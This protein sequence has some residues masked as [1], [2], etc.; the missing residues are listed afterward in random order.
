MGMRPP[1]FQRKLPSGNKV[2]YYQAYDATGTRTSPM[3]TWQRCKTA[4]F[5]VCMERLRRENERL[6]AMV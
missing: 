1:L 2:Y 5:V 3:S 6:K 4:A